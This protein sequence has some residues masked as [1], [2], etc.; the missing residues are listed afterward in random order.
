MQKQLSKLSKDDLIFMARVAEQS[1]RYQDM[2][3]FIKKILTH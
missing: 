2:I 1:E 3:E